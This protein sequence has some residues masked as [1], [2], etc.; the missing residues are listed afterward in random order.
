MNLIKIFNFLNL[1][2]LEDFFDLNKNNRYLEVFLKDP[3][4]IETKKQIFQ[5]L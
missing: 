5:N 3:K 1:N 4:N 2:D